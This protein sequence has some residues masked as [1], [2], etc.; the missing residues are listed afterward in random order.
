MRA[1]E[2]VA[3]RLGNTPTICRKCYVHPAVLEA[4]LDGSVLEALRTSSEEALVKDLHALRPEEAAVLA[5]LQQRLS[6]AATSSKPAKRVTSTKRAK[7][8]TAR[9]E[10][11]HEQPTH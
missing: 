10:S 3:S 4:Y 7:Q 9:Q 5:M 1:I 6:M 2:S 8:P 11:P